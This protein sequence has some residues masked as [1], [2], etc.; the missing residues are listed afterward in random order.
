ML[1]GLKK[2]DIAVTPY[3]ATKNWELSNVA[4][5]DVVLAE[6]GNPVASEKV[7]YFPTYTVPTSICAVAKENQD[8]DLLSYRE[9]LKTSGL[10]FPELESKN[11]DGTYKRLV[12]T[13]VKTMFYN[14]FRDPTK[15]WGTEKIDF[16][17][18]ETKK[19]LSD[20]IKVFSIPQEIMG[21]NIIKN[22][23]ILTDNTLD[24]AYSI[25]DDGKCNLVAGTNLFSKEQLLGYFQNIFETGSNNTCDSYFIF[26]APDTP[27]LTGSVVNITGSEAT[28]SLS[29]TLPGNSPV[30]FYMEKAISGSS[31][32]AAFSYFPVSSLS[33]YDF[34]II[35]SSVYYYRINAYNGWGSSSWSNVVT[36]SFVPVPTA[37]SLIGSVINITG[38]AATSS[39]SWT[40]PTP[41]PFGFYMEKAI[42]GSSPFAAF[43]YFPVSSLSV[44][45]FPIVTGSTYYRINA[46][47]GTGTSSWSNVVTLSFTGSSACTLKDSNGNEYVLGPYDTFEC[48]DS[49]SSATNKGYGW[50]ESWEFRRSYAPDFIMFIAHDETSYLSGSSRDFVDGGEGWSGSW[51]TDF[52]PDTASVFS[53]SP[54]GTFDF[55]GSLLWSAFGN[56]YLT[57]QYEIYRSSSANTDFVY[58][59]NSNISTPNVTYFDNGLQTSS[60]YIYKVRNVNSVPNYTS[61]FTST[62]SITTGIFPAVHTIYRDATAFW[63]L[64]EHSGS[65]TDWVG[66]HNLT[67]N[68]TVSAS[69]GKVT[70]SAHFTLASS[71]F[72]SVTASVTPLDTLDSG[73]WTIQAW[74]SASSWSQYCGVVIFNNMGIVETKLTKWGI[75]TAG[76]VS[77]TSR[78]PITNS[79]WTHLVARKSGSNRTLFINGT[80][81]TTSL[82]PD[83][84]Y[85]LGSVYWLGRGWS[86][87]YYG[88]RLDQV[89]VWTRPLSQ[90]EI[91]QL[92]NNGDGL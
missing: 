54:L 80:E 70:G 85:A 58:I 88:G 66:G 91:I 31:P 4:N 1:K 43:S 62:A 24:N 38:S 16:D 60:T 11:L 25:S 65:R 63:N 89:A 5:N 59:G 6:N 64:D 84:N 42:S 48:Y 10:F 56:Q 92:Y 79:V 68:N 61:S 47:N 46:Y 40:L 22:T 90:T 32:F 72:L 28:S 57:T 73:D 23:V 86:N 27:S 49:G 13:Q 21:E 37:P 67:D 15:V 77:V 39:L 35:T 34:P 44:Y 14:N 87:V 75:L 55:T 41:S 81:N 53:A 17:T 18:S 74:A 2:N 20:Y 83:A 45:D 7:N 50:S 33:V 51:Y 9:G 52:T 3:V 71:E 8:A 26:D 30:G 29:W 82:N 19:F 76:D 12:Y 78:N 69:I 36:L